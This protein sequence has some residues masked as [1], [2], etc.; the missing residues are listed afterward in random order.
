ML[1][2]KNK[3]AAAPAVALA[4][5]VQPYLFFNGRAADAIAFYKTALGAEAEMLM[6]FKDSP[7]PQGAAEKCPGGM[8]INPNWVMHACLKIGE[9]RVLVSDGMPQEKSSFQGFSL[10]LTARSDA[11]CDRLFKALGEGGQVQ[12]PLDKTFFAE[13]F[14]AV[15]DR[16]GVSWM[17]IY[18][19][20]EHQQR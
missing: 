20:P 4:N 5:V 18:P 10:S 6:H 11:E 7:A 2:E 8:T 12:M 16:F 13:R 15:Q 1:I 17:V 14:G 9:S 19:L 3:P